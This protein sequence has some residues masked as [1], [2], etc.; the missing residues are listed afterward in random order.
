M[1]I[2][3][4][5]AATL[6]SLIGIGTAT[7]PVL[8]WDGAW[9][10][11]TFLA[12]IGLPQMLIWVL[13]FAISFAVISKILSKA[14]ATLISI[15]IGFLALMAAPVGLVL[16]IATM[17]TGLIVLAIGLIVLIALLEIAGV[18]HGAGF[19]KDG[20]KVEGLRTF[21]AHPSAVAAILLAV[22]AIIFVAAGGLPLIGISAIP[23]I[24]MGTW[25]LI[26]VG[27]GVLWMLSEAK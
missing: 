10:V 15:V 5:I 8:A 16:V 4:T 18:R 3:Q 26:I 24:G 23:T 11:G 17:S 20:K 19:T 21:E 12:G 7:T 27:V 25:L 2:K 6:A 22:A 13:A 14:P 1:D 9:A